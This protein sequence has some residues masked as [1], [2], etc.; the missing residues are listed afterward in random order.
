MSMLQELDSH[1]KG[2]AFNFN[3]QTG[4][5]LALDSSTHSNILRYVAI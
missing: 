4:A 3:K 1:F 2:S 5:K